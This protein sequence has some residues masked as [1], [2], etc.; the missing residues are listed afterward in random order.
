MDTTYLE[1]I[2]DTPQLRRL[3]VIVLT[4]GFEQERGY[5]DLL[6]HPRQRPRTEAVDA[7]G[8]VSFVTALEAFWL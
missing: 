2:E 5:R 6:S 3:P 1:A 7:R 8:V 4:D